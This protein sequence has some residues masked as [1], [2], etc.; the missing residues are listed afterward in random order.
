MECGL[1]R[2]RSKRVLLPARKRKGIKR[3]TCRLV[4]FT[5]AEYEYWLPR[6]FHFFVRF[7]QGIINVV[8]KEVKH[9][10]PNN[11]IKNNQKKGERTKTTNKGTSKQEDT[12]ENKITSKANKA[13]KASKAKQS[14]K[15]DTNIH[16]RA[17]TQ[18]NG[19][20]TA[21]N[22]RFRPQITAK[23]QKR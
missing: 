20:L 6:F 5:M 13:S 18:G 10:K 14:K 3:R 22:K 7:S 4:T 9:N 15:P 17:C 21:M 23:L 19:A 8:D 11:Q 2:S 1:E 12:K 16:T